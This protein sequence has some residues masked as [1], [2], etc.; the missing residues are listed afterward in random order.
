MPRAKLQLTRDHI[1]KMLEDPAFYEAVPEYLFLRESVRDA[2]AY[3][4]SVAGC[5]R[6]KHQW[7]VMRG[8]CD[9][10]FVKLRSLKETNPDAVSRIK[11]WVSQKKGYP[12]TRCVLYYRRS[13]SQGRIAKFEF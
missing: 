11:E 1:I 7:N 8:C 6:C 13:R 4:A 10:F 5:I 12:V 3:L 2:Q 9:A